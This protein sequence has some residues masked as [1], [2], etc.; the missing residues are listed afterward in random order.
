MGCLC[1]RGPQKIGNSV[2][3]PSSTGKVIQL[4]GYSPRV[5]STP[6][7][8]QAIARATD[9]DFIGFTWEE[10][11]HSFYGLKCADFA[12][13]YDVSTG[14]WHERASYGLSSWRWSFVLHAYEKWIVGDA[15]TG[16]LGYLSA[17]TFTE[18]GD[19]LRLENTS[20]PVGQDNIR[21]THSRVELVFEQGV[22]ILTGQGS[23]PKVMLQFSDDG[24]RTWSNER[25]RS[26][27]RMGEFKRRTIWW[28]NG[29]SRDRIYRYSMSDPVRRTLILATT[30]S[31]MGLGRMGR[32]GQRRAG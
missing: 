18:F 16:A 9:R 3:F 28:R 5:I 1:P 4:D 32:K 24:G 29:K 23:D 12:F 6:A 11:G 22:G 31:R 7:I 19:T 26:L 14:L 15:E 2:F 25:W 20:P 30:K 13:V 21:L 10:P 17:N 27:G 8:E